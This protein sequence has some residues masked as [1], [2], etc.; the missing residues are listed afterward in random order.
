MEKVNVALAV[1]ARTLFDVHYVEQM[2]PSFRKA[3]ESDHSM[4]SMVGPIFTPEDAE[5]AIHSF[6]SQGCDLLVLLLATFADAT[7]VAA[8]GSAL[9]APILLWALTEPPSETGWLRLNSYCGA[10]L[11]ANALTALGRPFNFVYGSPENDNTLKELQK[12]IRVRATQKKMRKSRIGIF[13]VRPG[14]YYAC[15]FD[16]ME[17][18]RVLGPAVEYAFLSDLQSEAQS[19]SSGDESNFLADLQSHV[20]GLEKIAPQQ[21]RGTARSYIALRTLAQQRGYDAV[22][23]RCW[24]EFFDDYGHAACGALSRLND[25]GIIA[26]CE[27]DVNATA[28]MLALNGLHGGISFVVDVVAADFKENTWLLW[29][30]GAGPLSMASPNRE[31]VAG[32]QP[33][34]KQGLAFWFGMKPGPVTVAR[35]SYQRGRYRLW[36]TEGEALDRPPSYSQGSSAVVRMRGDALASAKRF[37]E[38]G[39]EHHVV[40]CYGHLAEEMSMLAKIWDVELI[41]L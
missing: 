10:T 9:N 33:N 23:V 24:P 16:E 39:F 1:I 11:A 22:A 26:G 31:V 18:R 3:L 19:V 2:M 32:Y 4:V 6:S 21:K 28:T 13:G 29:H 8:L 34:R 17:L 5:K 14:G 12:H 40:M 25:N 37:V 38:L 36:V 20:V 41:Q 30:C 7:P 15:N 27:A 35:L